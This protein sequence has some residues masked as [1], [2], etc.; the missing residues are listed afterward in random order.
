MVPLLITK[1]VFEPSDNDLKFIDQNHNYFFTSW[2]NSFGLCESTGSLSMCETQ[3]SNS[4][5][6]GPVVKSSSSVKA[7]VKDLWR[8]ESLRSEQE[9]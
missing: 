8:K 1:D 9:I 4:S 5:L 7:N 2:N 6:G 3:I